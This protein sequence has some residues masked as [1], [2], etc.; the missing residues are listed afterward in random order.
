ISQ[1]AGRYP[2][3]LLGADQLAA[4]TPAVTLAGLLFIALLTWV[5]YRG[6]EVS[7]RLQSVLLAV[8][9]GV[10]LLFA[11]VALVKAWTGHALP[12]AAHPS[13]GWLN[14]FGGSA[15]TL[16][17]AFLLAVFIYWGWDC[18]LSVNEETEDR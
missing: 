12:T 10:L 11:A 3:L 8:E 9:L 6:N 16:A 4:G 15:G 1:I 17:D 2:F 7:A 5:C 18:A 13:V 14:P